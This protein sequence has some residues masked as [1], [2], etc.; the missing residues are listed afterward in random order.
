[1]DGTEKGE[2]QTEFTTGIR[3]D[4]VGTKERNGDVLKWKV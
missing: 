1:M 3:L 4:K 2:N